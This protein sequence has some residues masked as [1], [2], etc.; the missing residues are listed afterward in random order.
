MSFAHRSALRTSFARTSRA[1]RAKDFRSG[2]TRGCRVLGR[3]SPATAGRDTGRGRG[4][5]FTEAVSGLIASMRAADYSPASIRNVRGQLKPFGAWLARRQI[6][7]LRAVTPAVAREYQAHVAGEKISRPTKALRIRAAKQLYAFLTEQGVL[8][9]DPTTQLKVPRRHDSLP[10]PVLTRKET[11]RLLVIPKAHTRYG[12]RA[13]ALFEVMYGS[14]IR[15]GELERVAVDD[16]DLRAQTLHLR[17]TKTGRPRVV[18]LGRHATH[19]LQKYLAEVRPVL[20]EDRPGERALFLVHGGRPM[21]QVIIRQ[22]FAH[23]RKRAK[24]RKA[25]S[26]HLL[27]HAC[28]THLLKAGA[29][30]RSIQELL[31][32]VRISTTVIYTRVAPLDVKA[33]HERY[34]PGNRRNVAL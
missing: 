22:T 12:I 13:R 33:T 11:A 2:P 16:V 32:H 18:P 17:H 9:L 31:G 14:G 3:A 25:V 23:F 10:R 8:L 24:L 20:V 15:V 1:G 19:W 21:R 30:L 34:H 26:P 6:S 29:D 5:S 27:R 4:L 28:A 7:D